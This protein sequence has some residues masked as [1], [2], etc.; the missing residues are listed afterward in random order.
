VANW[1]VLTYG[2]QQTYIILGAVIA[3]FCIP[4]AILI[5]RRTPEEMGTLPD[6]AATRD[7]KATAEA[8][9]GFTLGQA[10]KLP[11]F[12]MLAGMILFVSTLNMGIQQHLIPYLTD[13]G[14]SPTFAANIMAVYLGMTIAG[15]LVLGRI[16]DREGVT[17]GFVV[18]CVILAVGIGILFG[19][20]VA[21][22]AVL[23]GVVYGFANAIQT[24]VPPLMTADG[25]GLKHYALI[26]GVM[27]IFSTLGAGIGMPLSGYIY[28]ATGSYGYAFVLYI[29]LTLLLMILG[30][31]A[32]RRAKFARKTAS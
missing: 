29:V 5:M 22:V 30:I 4:T 28:D 17:R 19:A 7:K 15:K 12:W 20:K 25:L 14:H 13:L 8:A 24:V 16:S 10:V 26:Y 6:G 21:W 18:F 1:L 9:A 31:L 27:N 3:I 11:I 23:F 32:M 2:W